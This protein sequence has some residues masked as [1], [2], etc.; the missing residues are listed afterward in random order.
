MNALR[1]NRWSKLHK[2][3]DGRKLCV[4][5]A[6]RN[7]SFIYHRTPLNRALELIKNERL[8]LRCVELWDDPYEAWWC[9]Q[10]FDRKHSPLHGIHAYGSC[11]AT[12]WAD[13][14]AWRMAGYRR[15]EPIVRL[16]IMTSDLLHAAQ[17]S[18]EQHAG[19]WYLGRVRYKTKDEL[20]Q[21]AAQLD[22]KG[23]DDASRVRALKDVSG[24]AASLLLR[25]RTA[26][27]FEEEIRLV[28]LANPGVVGGDDYY[29]P[30]NPGVISQVMVS[31]Y[32]KERY[33]EIAQQIEKYGLPVVRS[34]I[35]DPPP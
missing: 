7:C 16:K 21:L 13:E 3:E 10:I 22:Q 26:F 14:P 20:L 35:L 33:L 23:N 6:L 25:K 15:R 24:T 5:D 27:R 31:P 1:L 34:E 29:L 8:H 30:F 17:A 9:R 19:S 18:F 2:S 12:N 28:Y 11:W 32:E 4:E